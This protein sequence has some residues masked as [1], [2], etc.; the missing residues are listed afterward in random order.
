MM[1]ILT[2]KI[3]SIA[4]SVMMLC[5]TST[6]RIVAEDVD[7]STTSLNQT[8]TVEI[9]ESI[10]S[11]QITN[12]KNS[13]IQEYENIENNEEDNKEITVVDEADKE[14]VD[15]SKQQATDN[16]KPSEGINDEK[17]ED[18]SD[19][20]I[21]EEKEIIEE[22]PVKE[23]A[24]MAKGIGLLAEPNDATEENMRV[25]VTVSGEANG[26][27]T[28]T[29]S[30]V[31]FA[32]G[33]EWTQEATIYYSFKNVLKLPD[34][35][36]ISTSDPG[37]QVSY[38]NGSTLVVKGFDYSSNINTPLVITVPAE[39][40]TE[41]TSVQELSGPGNL[42]INSTTSSYIWR[43]GH[44]LYFKEATI[45]VIGVGNQFTSKLIWNNR[46]VSWDPVVGA[47][48]YD[49]RYYC[50]NGEVVEKNITENT[51]NLSAYINEN[52]ED[53]YYFQVFGRRGDLVN[54]IPG[55]VSKSFYEIKASP[56]YKPYGKGSYTAGTLGGTVSGSA[57]SGETFTALDDG[58]ITGLFAEGDKVTITV[59]P[60]TNSKYV[61][62]SFNAGNVKIEGNVY[63]FIVEKLQYHNISA[64]FVEEKDNI[65]VTLKWSSIDNKKVKEDYVISIP[66]GT[67]LS[68]LDEEIVD[69]IEN[70]FSANGYSTLGSIRGI[71]APNPITSYNDM[72]D[73]D[74]YWTEDLEENSVLYVLMAKDLEKVSLTVEKPLCGT[75]VKTSE[76]FEQENAPKLTV[77]E[78]SLV[79]LYE[80]LK[81]MWVDVDEEM[82]KPLNNVTLVGGEQYTAIFPGVEAEFGY[83]ISNKTVIEIKNSDK[84]SESEGQPYMFFSVTAEHDW[85]FDKI[86]WADDYSSAKALY[87]CKADSEH[88]QEVDC[89][90]S[91]ETSTKGT[92]YTATV[93]AENSLDKKEHS[94]KHGE[95]A[96]WNL[97]IQGKHITGEICDDILGDGTVSY[98][99]DTNTITLN[100]ASIEIT[101]REYGYSSDHNEYG[102]RA[103]LHNPD[104]EVPNAVGIEGVLTINL[105]GTNTISN[106]KHEGGTEDIYGIVVPDGT[107]NG[108]VIFTGGGTL[109]IQMNASE[110]GRE[111]V[112]IQTRRDTT[113]DGVKINI[114]IPGSQY[115]DGYQF[116]Y[117]KTVSLTNKAE[118]HISTGSKGY[119]FNSTEEG[120]GNNADISVA[121]GCVFEAKSDNKAVNNFK[122]SSETIRLGALVNTVNSME[123][124][125]E[126]SE[127]PED[128][129]TYKYIRIPLIKTA[130]ENIKGDGNVWTKGSKS[131]S[132]F[133]FKR[134]IND[135]KTYDSF[136]DIEIDGKPVDRNNYDSD[137]GSVIIKLKPSYL[138][139]LSVGSHTIKAIFVDGEAEAN[140]TVKQSSTKRHV[141]PKTGV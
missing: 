108:A 92:I 36:K 31:Q 43:S 133:T 86:E 10:D 35:S 25:D 7:E 42:V 28:I 30:A 83:S 13:T 56:H 84:I 88:T 17:T 47:T 135:S 79:K 48:S 77:D 65:S 8:E 2:K 80:Y 38:S 23:N 82:I 74:D 93:S 120:S 121:E 46:T 141:M 19:E 128:L 26:P 122:V 101:K 123:G 11:K 75:V 137:P 20:E 97:Y 85:V 100:N 6:V 90:V 16:V 96:V 115:T 49:I 15:D 91:K 76:Y 21:S 55:Y 66:F 41:S 103:N 32:E 12:E 27:Y 44:D 71:Y 111:Y 134:N 22:I 132:D 64:W 68:D 140:F 136:K 107:Y 14:I 53:D 117:S 57:E 114:D 118:L 99:P 40:N 98:N 129:S 39:L 59:T 37:A 138:E 125:D 60:N 124:S 1:N 3:V 113:L 52:G 45:P 9:E 109:N 87:Y 18:L 62:D 94:D 81:P 63:N 72:Y 61:L 33:A 102:I 126:F 29:I 116:W 24:L 78:G 119:A 34:V 112:G 54:I 139:K 5:S 110:S 69:R 106:G 131:T 51:Y 127:V 50:R 95:Y 70:Y 67:S 4:L 104:A 105:I 73:I 58:V 89:T 130:Y